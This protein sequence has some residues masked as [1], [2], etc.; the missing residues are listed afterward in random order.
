M[1]KGPKRTERQ[2]SSN[3]CLRETRHHVLAAHA[4]AGKEDEYGEC[5]DRIRI[6]VAT[7][8]NEYARRIRG[9]S[10]HAAASTLL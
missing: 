4:E 10:A 1:N 5:G 7:T 6:A 3:H 2:L 9:S 8:R